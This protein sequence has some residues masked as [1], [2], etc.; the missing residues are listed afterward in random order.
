MLRIGREGRQHD[1]CRAI[2]GNPAKLLADLPAKIPDLAERAFLSE[3]IS[4]YRVSAYRAA[5]VMT[6]NLAFDHLLNWIM[7]DAARIAAFNTA[8]PKRLSKS[9]V[10]IANRQDFDD[11]C[12]AGRQSRIC[13]QPACAG[14]QHQCLRGHRDQRQYQDQRSQP[15]A[16]GNDQPRHVGQECRGFVDHRAQQ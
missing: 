2:V 4:C 8:V 10:V 12:R 13:P 15:R 1:D 6:W 14:Q 16:A 7:L 11:L 3:A 9:K 5:I